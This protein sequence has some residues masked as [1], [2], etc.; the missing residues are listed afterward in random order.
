MSLPAEAKTRRLAEQF[1]GVKVP[2][3][4]S[5]R[6]V[7]VVTMDPNFDHPELH[8]LD[9][10]KTNWNVMNVV[11]LRGDFNQAIEYRQKVHR[12]PF[13][14]LP[15]A[16]ATRAQHWYHLGF[17]PQAYGCARLAC[18]LAL[19]P[20]KDAPLKHADADGAIRFASDALLNIRSI[21]QV[22]FAADTLR[23]VEPVLRSRVDDI[24]GETKARLLAE[25][26][27]YFRDYGLPVLAFQCS[28]VAAHH[29]G[30]PVTLVQKDLGVRLLQHRGMALASKGKRAAEAVKRYFAESEE[31]QKQTG[32]YK[33]GSG[34]KDLWLSRIALRQGLPDLHRM[35][36]AISRGEKALKRGILSYW[37]WAELLRDHMIAE[38][39]C[40]SKKKGKESEDLLEELR[41][42]VSIPPTALLASQPT[43]RTPESLEAFRGNALRILELLGICSHP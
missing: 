1:Y 4:S 22:Q 28:T 13:D 19:K 6:L 34:T 14:L 31:I 17:F 9:E 7:C 24:T 12:L 41:R 26:G 23:V 15:N 29:L 27:S 32:A 16:L 20:Y 35:R 25:I 42:E 5:R 18:H 8:H 10:D 40:G 37:T 39:M 33:E 36:E 21:H 2:A 38:R 30:S 3:S 11:P 43:P